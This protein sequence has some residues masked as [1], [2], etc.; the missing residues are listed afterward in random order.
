MVHIFIPTSACLTWRCYHFSCQSGRT[1]RKAD[2]CLNDVSLAAF[3]AS[4]SNSVSYLSTH[5]WIHVIYVL[6]VAVETPCAHNGGS[7][8]L[9]MN[10]LINFQIKVFL[11]RFGPRN[12]NKA[13]HY[14]YVFSTGYFLSPGF[15][16][17]MPIKKIEGKSNPIRLVIPHVRLISNSFAF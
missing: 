9:K 2:L 15:C 14:R 10:A 1:G 11:N 3:Y 13:L 4:I 12:N 7:L 5:L 17:F 8:N 16:L 6:Q